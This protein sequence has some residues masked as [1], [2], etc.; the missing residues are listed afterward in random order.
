MM[1]VL[2]EAQPSRAHSLPLPTPADQLECPAQIV[3]V[4]FGGG[5]VGHGCEV[6]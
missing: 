2:P 1:R 3:A 5:H 6:K 4:H